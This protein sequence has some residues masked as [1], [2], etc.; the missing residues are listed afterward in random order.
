[1]NASCTS[2]CDYVV[3]PHNSNLSNGL[4]FEDPELKD[5]QMISKREPL[6]EIF[7]HKGSS[8][9]MMRMIHIV[10]LNY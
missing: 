10:I 3:I 6:I 2:D 1:M 7:Q 8:E 5:Y 4:I 9:C